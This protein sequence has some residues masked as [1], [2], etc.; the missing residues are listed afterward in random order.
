MPPTEPLIAAKKIP[1]SC[2]G[3]DGGRG[4]VDDSLIRPV[5][6]SSHAKPDA[7]IGRSSRRADLFASAPR[8]LIG[9]SDFVAPD[10]E[11]RVRSAL[12]TRRRAIGST[13]LE[14]GFAI[15]SPP[16]AAIASAS[17]ARLCSDEVRAG[18]VF[19]LKVSTARRASPHSRTLR[20]NTGHGRIAGEVLTS[21]TRRALFLLRSFLLPADLSAR[22]CVPRKA[23]FVYFHVH[24]EKHGSET[25]AWL[26]LCARFVIQR[27]RRG[28]RRH[29]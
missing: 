22:Q 6:R 27:G 1:E 15:D 29:P 13:R 24:L 18:S 23:I 5:R 14:H 19:Y 17:L 26:V 4:S 25:G 9:H 16:H 3:D 21:P 20:C 12:R 28:R 10:F 11:G 7:S 8:R 2:L